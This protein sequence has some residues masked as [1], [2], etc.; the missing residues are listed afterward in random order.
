MSLLDADDLRQVCRPPCSTIDVAFS[1]LSAMCRDDNS[2]RNKP[3][4]LPA[5]PV[6][7]ALDGKVARGYPLQRFAAH[8]AD[9]VLV[10][11]KMALSAPSATRNRLPRLRSVR[12]LASGHGVRWW[13]WMRTRRHHSG[14]EIRR[15]LGGTRHAVKRLL[16]LACFRGPQLHEPKKYGI[17]QPPLQIA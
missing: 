15:V 5:L 9:D 8:L 13:L 2:S 7:D 11:V 4:T 12:R 3:K 1:N 6:S 17:G 16:L 14:G 10:G